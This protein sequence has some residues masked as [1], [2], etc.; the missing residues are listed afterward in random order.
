MDR[1]SSGS[2]EDPKKRNANPPHSRS[3]RQEMFTMPSRIDNASRPSGHRE[4]SSRPIPPSGYNRA[5]GMHSHGTSHHYSRS[6]AESRSLPSN[7]ATL[8]F[9]SHHPSANYP[10]PP[11]HNTR[12]SNAHASSSRPNPTSASFSM[13]STLMT[14]YD[15]KMASRQ[16]KFETL[17]AKDQ[18]EQD[19][20]AQSQLQQNS[21][22]CVMGYDWVRVEGGYR[23]TGGSHKVT[24]ELLAEGKG[25]YY[26][27]NL[28]ELEKLG[29]YWVGPFYSGEEILAYLDKV[30]PLPFG[31][32]R[33][34]RQGS[35]G[36]GIGSASGSQLG[37]GSL[38]GGRSAMGGSM[39][40]GSGMGGSRFGPRGSG[41]GGRR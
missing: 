12:P 16:S 38:S 37:G 26:C 14:E 29:L 35:Q 32:R 22:N 28:Y 20:W 21:G 23:C 31:G 30:D 13:K 41:T 4:T 1:P 7:A 18:T 24:D 9:N 19:R 34:Q 25:G 3:L 17:S 8:K 33:R 36:H 40:G 11:S 2:R 5:S 39:M 6:G 27:R 15:K 10:S